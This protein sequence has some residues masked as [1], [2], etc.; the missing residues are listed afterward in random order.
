MAASRAR[1]ARAAA[2][3]F[4]IST[5]SLTMCAATSSGLTAGASSLSS[6]GG[7]VVLL[8][9]LVLV[10]AGGVCEYARD[11]RFAARG[12]LENLRTVPEPDAAQLVE[13][14]SAAEAGVAQLERLEHSISARAP[15][16]RERAAYE[17]VDDR[18]AQAPF[19]TACR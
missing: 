12:G 16:R 19:V 6:I 3:A 4:S 1:I 7:V 5:A 18:L 17:E 14:L 9:F 8:T 2:A 11:P 10:E 13:V 15:D